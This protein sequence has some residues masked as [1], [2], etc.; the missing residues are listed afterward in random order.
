MCPHIALI[1]LSFIVVL[2]R[3]SMHWTTRFL[4]K[5]FKETRV[6]SNQ[7]PTTHPPAE[8]DYTAV[9]S[10]AAAL[11]LHRRCT[12]P[13][14]LLHCPERDPTC[15]ELSGQIEQ[16][17][18][19]VKA[20]KTIPLFEAKQ[21]RL[22]LSRPTMNTLRFKTEMKTKLDYGTGASWLQLRPVS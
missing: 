5:A 16:T 13:A 11:A 7:R 12:T 4:I 9:R 19:D 1:T 15:L 14:L 8:A 3:K 20:A 10:A 17:S 21:T 2:D 18:Y 22:S 6:E